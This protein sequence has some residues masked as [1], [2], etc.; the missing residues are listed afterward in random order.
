[1]NSKNVIHSLRLVASFALLGAVVAGAFLGWA[2]THD[3][4][5]A[6]A[7][8]GAAAGILLKTSHVL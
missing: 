8:L 6:G 1:M 3:F 4:R 7:V 2:E 5:A